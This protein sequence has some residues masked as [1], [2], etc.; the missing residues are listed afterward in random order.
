[1]AKI[2]TCP[3]CGQIGERS[4][5]HV[6]AQWLHETPGAQ[7]LLSE[8]HGERIPNEQTFVSRT[9][10]GRLERRTS[11]LGAYA[12]DLPHLTVWV[13]RKC[14]SGWMSQLEE[15]AKRLLGPFILGGRQVVKLSEDD[16][17][18]LAGWATKSWMAYS[19]TRSNIS[20]PFSDADYRSIATSSLPVGRCLIWL[21]HS[22]EARAHVGIG[23]TSTYLEQVAKPPMD[24]VE[25]ADNCAF[26][27][28]AVASCVLF[29]LR[30]PEDFPLE[31]EWTMVPPQLRTYGTRQIW[32]S[33]R[34][35]YFPLDV[36][37]DY[38]FDR[39]L[40][41]PRLLAEAIALPTIGLTKQERAEVVQ[42]FLDGT[43]PQELRTRWEP[44]SPPLE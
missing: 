31:V 11:S 38:D 30:V 44:E 20:N 13:C 16:L 9:S 21:L 7:Y 19:L 37:P 32:P 18:R 22:H 40:D 12:R 23:I 36:M 39:L 25:V 24:L 33:Q 10:D 26:A 2:I 8:S 6:W 27:Y 5:E 17:R 1:M 34:R 43:D 15:D 41:Y 14:N 28:L 35:Q 4:K 42:Q 29:M 3:F